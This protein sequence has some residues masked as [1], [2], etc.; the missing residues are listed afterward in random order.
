MPSA[1]DIFKGMDLYLARHTESNY[2]VAGLS[3]SKPEINVHLTKKGHNQAKYLAELL[4]DIPLDVVFTS[5]LSRTFETAKYIIEGRNTPLL[6]DDRLNDLNMGFEGQSVDEY[7]AALRGVTD[8]WA[9]KFNDGESMND[10]LERVDDYLKYLK[11]LTYTSVL[12]ISHYTVLQLVTA[13]VNGTDVKEALKFNIEQGG[14]T[15]IV[16]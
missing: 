5:Q 8:E 6:K 7:H 10:L 9:V 15:K 4:R 3:N 1:S 11:T 14:F 13:R 16:L 12:I 2:N